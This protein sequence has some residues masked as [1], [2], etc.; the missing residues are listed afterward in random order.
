MPRTPE[1]L[2]RFGL[3]VGGV[4]L[5]LGGVSAW[6][7]HD[8]VPLVV[9]P[10]GGMLLVLGLGAPASLAPLE[11]V[12]MRLAVALGRFNASV[13]LTVFFYGVITPL[14]LVIRRFRDPMNRNLERHSTSGWVWR[15]TS[16]ADLETYRRQF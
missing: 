15:D 8:L 2:R 3:T 16:A 1:E 11:A 5:V 10:L 13:I 14:G 7:G 4:L 6:R 12:W 9:G